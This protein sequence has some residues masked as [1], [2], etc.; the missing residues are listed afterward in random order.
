MNCPLTLVGYVTCVSVACGAHRPHQAELPERSTVQAVT[1]ERNIHKSS[2]ESSPSDYQIELSIYDSQRGVIIRGIPGANNNMIQIRIT[3]PESAQPCSA[4]CDH[5]RDVIVLPRENGIRTINEKAADMS[6]SSKAERS[7]TP[8]VSLGISQPSSPNSSNARV[9]KRRLPS[10]A[11][12]RPP[13]IEA[14][15]GRANGK[16][17]P[18]FMKDYAS[19]VAPPVTTEAE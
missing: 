17:T 3:S 12:E 7:N 1:P 10:H 6:Q 9:T 15:G 8:P 4:C 16:L 2:T 14:N 11:S 5:D 18:S 19:P 13:K